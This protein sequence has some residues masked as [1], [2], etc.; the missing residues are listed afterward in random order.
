MQ[1]AAQSLDQLQNGDR[2]RFD[3]GFHGP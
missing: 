3:D 1:V 2:L